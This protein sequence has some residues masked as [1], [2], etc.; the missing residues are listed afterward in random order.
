MPPEG[1]RLSVEQVSLLRAWIDQGAAW[2]VEGDPAADAGADHWSFSPPVRHQPPAVADVSWVRSPIDAFVLARLEAAGLSPSPEAD[3]PTLI[4]RLSLDLLGLPPS[5]DEVAQFL[6]DEAP[7]AYERLVDRLL[8][9]PHYGERWGRHWLDLARYADSNGYDNDEPRPDAWRYRDWVIDALNRDMPF[10]E[11]TLRQLAG[12]LLP[13]ATFQDRLATGF[14]R[15]TPTNTEGG[16]DREEFRVR[17]VVDRV[18]TTGTDWLGLTVG[19][20]QCH[21][22]KYDPLSQREFYR[23]FAFFDNAEEVETEGPEGIKAQ[24]LTAAAAPRVTR[25]LVR[26]D[27]LQPGEEVQA[28]TPAVLHAFVAPSATQQDQP[29]DATVQLAAAEGRGASPQAGPTRLDLA[30]WLMAPDNPLTARVTANRV[31]QHLFG[32]GLVATPDDFG[33]QGSP[34]THLE[35][36]DWLATELTARGW[37]QKELIR[38]IVGSAA[39]RQA[40]VV[41]PESA[42]CDPEN[43]LLGRQNR[44][45]LDGELVRD[46]AL[47]AAGLLDRR[48]GGPSFY[49]PLPAAM[50]V[51]VRWAISPDTEQRRRGMYIC[52]QRALPYPMLATFDAPDSHVACTRRDRSNTPLQALVLLNDEQFFA[53]AQALGRRAAAEPGGNSARIQFAFRAC[54]ARW[55]DDRELARIER[56]FAEQQAIYREE[57]G[58]PASLVGEGPLPEGVE[59]ADAAAWIGVARTLMNLDEFVTRE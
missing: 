26:G 16:V 32:R 10:D 12:D 53:C 24:V 58:L 4:R 49:P 29:S 30:R 56:L 50:T 23:L 43:L 5:P 19:C 34:P 2:P 18:S 51:G 8:A 3:R 42:E 35:L 6:A 36:L 41:R 52:T 59:L 47:A 54:L 7:G 15:N 11:F 20:A 45:R 1:P 28:G 17:T 27:H 25:V 44:Y 40:S 14:H 38:L 48:V 39:Y 31:W 46:A 22:H 33:T 13:G 55:P 37:S 21:S 9:S 57:R